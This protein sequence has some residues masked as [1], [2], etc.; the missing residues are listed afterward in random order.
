VNS[1]VHENRI[2]LEDMRGELRLVAEGVLGV[3][4]K[5][6][7]FRRP[8][9]ERSEEILSILRRL[10]PYAVLDGRVAALEDW[11]GRQGRDPIEVIRERYGP[12]TTP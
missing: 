2:L 6:E 8:S 3:D 5:L 7:S 9:E 4:E 1:S 12:K 10:P 11:R